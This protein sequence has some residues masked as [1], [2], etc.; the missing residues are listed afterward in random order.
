MF[1]QTWVLVSIIFIVGTYI[2]ESR[3]NYRRLKKSYDELES[4]FETFVVHVNE[5]KSCLD[6]HKF[7][8]VK[9][10]A[11]LEDFKM[12]MPPDDEVYE[13]I[14]NAT[15]KMLDECDFDKIRLRYYKFRDVQ[16]GKF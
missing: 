12:V 1:I 6:E 8:F 15:L 2:H 5:Q 10:M 3:K 9:K 16:Y 14:F 13:N 7:S 4:T 11:G